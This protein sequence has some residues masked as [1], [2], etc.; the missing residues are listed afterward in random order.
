MRRLAVVAAGAALALSGCSGSASRG[1]LPKGASSDAE[2][3]TNL[4]VNSWIAALV[5]GVLVWGLTIWCV[6]A[7]RRR[8]DDDDIPVQL[9]LKGYRPWRGTFRGGE[10]AQLEV[11]LER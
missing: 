4:W 9:R 10:P 7:Y 5:V 1:W 11:K 8:K 3:V 6:V 2:R